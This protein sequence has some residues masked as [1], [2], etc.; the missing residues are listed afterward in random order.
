MT[1]KSAK[2]VKIALSTRI[3]LLRTLLD[4]CATGTKKYDEETLFSAYTESIEAWQ[5]LY[6]NEKIKI[7]V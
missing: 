1:T 2:Q 7:T 4:K 3:K 5:Q 6:P